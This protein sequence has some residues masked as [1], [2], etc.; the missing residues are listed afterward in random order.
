MTADLPPP[1]WYDDPD[2]EP[3]N[4]D[5]QRWWDGTSWS[6]ARRRSGSDAAVVSASGT[7]S[8][9]P[10]LSSL[11]SSVSECVNVGGAG[12][13]RTLATPAER[14]A[15]VVIDGVLAVVVLAAAGL[16]GTIFGVLPD[17]MEGLVV[18]ALSLAAW[19]VVVGSNVMGEGR[20]GQSYGKHLV[21]L[22]VV[23]TRTG[24]HVGSAAALGRNIVRGVGVY[25]LGLGVLWMLW[26]P[27]RQGW[28]DKAASSVVV[29]ARR[30][31]RVDPLTFVRAI[32]ADDPTLPMRQRQPSG[33]TLTLTS[34]DGG[35]LEGLSQTD[36]HQRSD[37]HGAGAD[38]AAPP[39][40]S[41]PGR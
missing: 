34:D 28:H 30:P 41:S 24:G 32:L 26:D 18:G 27:R 23:S 19:V 35:T 40:Q 39:R 3:D 33:T 7:P 5:G 15:A 37:A 4:N 25:V 36:S 22:D 8:R 38:N 2:P 6:Q 31:V 13:L 10:S 16:V 17:A 12:E 20:L 9:N 21:G 14:L 29:K 1:G 11:A